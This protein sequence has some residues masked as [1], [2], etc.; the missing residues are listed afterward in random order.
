MRAL[1]AFS[2]RN[3]VRREEHLHWLGGVD[4]RRVFAIDETGS[5]IAMLP[6]RGWAPRGQRSHETVPRS[7]GTVLTVIGALTMNG[8]TA[9]MTV[10]GGTSGDVFLAYVNEVLLREMNPGDIVLMDNLGAHRDH[11][12]LEAFAAAGVEVHFQPPYSPEF[13]PIELAWA[14]VKWFLR[15]AKART[16]DALNTALAM[17]MDMIKP[18]EAAA[19]FAHC[20]FNQHM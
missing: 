12:V 11:R 8:L 18:A 16:Y 3:L 15:L 13:N 5:H 1:E 7:R 19:Y 10:E 9:V 4:G 17:V 6:A 14:K 20:G 2:E